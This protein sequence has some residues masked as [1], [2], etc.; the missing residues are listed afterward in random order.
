[1]EEIAGLTQEI[2]TALGDFFGKTMGI[3]NSFNVIFGAD[4]KL[5]FDAGTLSSLESQAVKQV[6]TDLNRYLAAEEA[7]EETEGMLSLELTGIGEKFV[8]LKEAVGKIHDQSLIPKD[9]FR[10]AL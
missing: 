5:S 1:M 3:K 2:G 8:A 9:G 4:G 10:F 6:I 7:G